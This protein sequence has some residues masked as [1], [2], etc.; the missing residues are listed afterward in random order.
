MRQL[1]YHRPQ[2]LKGALELLDNYGPQARVLAGGTDLLVALRSDNMPEKVKHIVDISNIGELKKIDLTA[3]EANLGPL[4]THAEIDKQDKLTDKIPFLQQ[5]VRAIG[6]PQIRTRGT[7]GGNICNAAPCA[8]TVP[9]LVALEAE[10]KLTSLREE[11]QMSLADFLTGPYQTARQPQ[12]VLTNICFSLPEEGSATAFM[13][14][15]RRKA[16]AISRMSVAAIIK[17][18]E[19]GRVTDFSL[20]TGSVTPSIRRLKEAEEILKGEK[21]EQKVLDQVAKEVAEQMI[22]SSGYRWSTSYKEPVIQTLVS[23][24]IAQALGEIS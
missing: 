11:R 17:L 10:V 18:N 22:A 15:G 9:P 16:L 4:V 19:Q 3:K 6:S 13:K 24:T 1:N 23:R 8:D 21:P 12:E 5:A 20:A 2:E 7:L 14:L